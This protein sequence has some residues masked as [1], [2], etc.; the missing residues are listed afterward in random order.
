M[1]DGLEQGVFDGQ[2]GAL[3]DIELA[4]ALGVADMGPVGGP[5]AGAAE[6]GRVTEGLQEHGT[7]PVADGT[8]DRG[9]EFW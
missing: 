5:I 8:P 9:G 3:V 2:G 7:P 1:V 4:A 6:T